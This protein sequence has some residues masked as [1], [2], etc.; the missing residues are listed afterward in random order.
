MKPLLLIIMVAA[1]VFVGC[2]KSRDS[3]SVASDVCGSTPK[4]FSGDVSPIIQSS[5]ATGSG[6]HGAGSSNGPGALTSYAQVFAAR[7]AISSAVS[8]GLM[9]KNAPLGTVQKNAII[10]W[11]NNGAPNN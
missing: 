3:S 10:C 1:I 4:T 6:C 7:T 2:K 5:C 9:P 8:S 11:I